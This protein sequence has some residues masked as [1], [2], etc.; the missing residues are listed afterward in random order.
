MIDLYRL[1]DCVIQR[2][3]RQA[4][5][6]SPCLQVEVVPFI[7]TGTAGHSLDPILGRKL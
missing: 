3:Y 4:M 6:A 1:G 2:V 7:N 5:S